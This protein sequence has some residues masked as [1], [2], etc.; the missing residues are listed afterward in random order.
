[1]ITRIKFTACLVISLLS[2]TMAGIAP[3]IAAPAPGDINVF[4]PGT[5]KGDTIIPD[6]WLR[7]WD[8]ITIFFSDAMGPVE[9]SPENEPDK[10]ASIEPFHPGSWRW[11][12]AKTLQFKPAEPWPAFSSFSIRA[13]KAKTDL[14]TV[15]TGP[16]NTQPTQ[17][18]TDLPPVETISLTF[19][20]TIPASSLAAALSVTLWSTHSADG[21]PCDVYTADDF[22]VKQVGENAS[23]SDITYLVTLH[24]PVPHNT[25]ARLR[26]DLTR[27]ATDTA[28][29]FLD[30]STARSFCALAAGAGENWLPLSLQS[31]DR[32]IADPL[33]LDI[34]PPV[35]TIRMSAPLELLTPTA[36]WDFVHLT[37]A[38]GKMEFA[39]ED[40]LLKINGDFQPDTVYRATIRPTSLIRDSR[41]RSL[42]LDSPIEFPFVFRCPDRVLEWDRN[43]VVVERY[44]PKM[45]PLKG[46]G[47]HVADVRLYRVDP[48]DRT[49]WPFPAE[50]ITTNPETKPPFPSGNEQYHDQTYYGSSWELEETLTTMGS[51]VLSDIVE[52]PLN[53]MGDVRT[54][55]LD[56]EKYL[57][58]LEGES[59]P[60]TYLA[61]VQPLNDPG[62]RHW[63][64][65]QITDLALTTFEE[66]D[67][68]TFMVTSLK[69]AAPVANARVTLEGYSNREW[70]RILS[71][72]TDSMGVFTQ[73]MPSG[74]DY[75]NLKRIRVERGNDVLVVDTEHPP[76]LF[77]YGRWSREGDW[78]YQ[79]VNYPS[80]S[81]RQSLVGHLFT[82]RPVYRPGDP[83]H[84]RGWIRNRDA[85]VFALTGDTSFQISVE[86]PGGLFWTAQVTA[87]PK[88]GIYNRFHQLD[89]PV[90]SYHAS[91]M[92]NGISIATCNFRMED[93][94]LP[95]FE[96]LL[97]A[98][99]TV[100]LD[101]AFDITLTAKYY[102]GGAMIDRPVSWRVTQHP[103]SWSA[104][105][106]PGFRFAVD[107]R[108]TSRPGLRENDILN[109]VSK[110]DADGSARISIDPLTELS[111]SPRNYVIEA[112]V[113]GVDGQTVTAVKQIEALP[114][115]MLGM[116]TPRILDPG[117]P[118]KPQI[119]VLDT[120]GEFEPGREII[121]R[122]IR[123]TWHTVLKAGNYSAGDLK[124]DT[125]IVETPIM[126]T[127]VVSTAE[128]LELSFPIGEAG[129]YIVEASARDRIG[130]AQT[131]AMDVFVQGQT[132]VAW[133]RAPD[134]TFL[135]K[136]GKAAYEPGDT[137][138]FLV[139][140]PFQ[141]A[142]AV[143]VIE[144]PDGLQFHHASVRNGVCVIDVPVRDEW[145][146]EIPVNVVLMRGRLP[147]SRIE[148][149]TGIDLGKPQT[150]ATSV[151]LNV[152]K[153]RHI[154]AI[155]IEH[156]AR[157]V[158]GETIDLTVSLKNSN[159]E[160]VAGEAAVWLVDRAV[161]ALGHE[162]S[163]DPLRDLLIPFRSQLGIRD[164]REFVA[165]LL[166]GIFTTG[167]GYGED[168]AGDIFDRM[169]L[170]RKFEPVPFYEPF[171]EIGS[172]G[173]AHLKVT[174]PDNL[175]EFAVRAKACSGIDR[176]GATESRLAV[177]L[178]VVMQPTLPRFLRPGDQFEALG[179]SR[180]VEGEAGAGRIAIQTDGLILTGDPVEQVEWEF[181]V[182][183]RTNFNLKVPS[184]SAENGD[185]PVPGNALIRMAAERLK[186]GV[187][188]AAE[189]TLPVI[190][191]TPD[192]T[193]TW[194]RTL[195]PGETVEV[196]GIDPLVILSETAQ[197]GIR[198]STSPALLTAIRAESLL[199][200]Y[201]YGCTE[202]RLSRA[203]GL[204]IMKSLH[205]LLNRS[206]DESSYDA[207]I[208][209]TIDYLPIVTTPEGLVAFWP[210]GKGYVHLT[211]RALRFLADARNSGF[212]VD[213][214][215][216][217]Q[218]IRSLKASL[219]SD[220]R[221]LV[222][223]ADVEERVLALEALT[224]FGIEE[225]GYIEEMARQADGLG[226]ETRA[227]IVRLFAGLENVD[228]ARLNGLA[229]SLWNDVVF[230]TL[231]GRLTATGFRLGFR[232]IYPIFMSNTTAL[233]EVI[234]AMIRIAP[235]DQRIQAMT[236]GLV[237]TMDAGWV[238]TYDSA[239]TLDVLKELLDSGRI[240]HPESIVEIGGQR[241]SV[242][243]TRPLVILNDF[244]TGAISVTKVDGAP[245]TIHAD[246]R[247]RPVT[248]PGETPGES[249]GFAVQRDWRRV[250]VENRLGDIM[251]PD[252][253]GMD[254]ELTN[255][256]IVE[257]HIQ[258]VNPEDRLYIVVSAPLAAGM[259]PLN[260]EL[261]IAPP[262]ARP[263]GT[264]TLDADYME[265]R[266]HYIAW[267]YN[268]LPKG[269]YD[270]YFRTRASFAGRFTQPGARA[271]MMYDLDKTG[272][273]PGIHVRIAPDK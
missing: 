9:I 210:G 65:I 123:R 29:F 41:G 137:A 135:L 103:A 164:T 184:T 45:L 25:K 156:P 51:P 273:S 34:N 265:I 61:G 175:T 24:H 88:G 21:K 161:L 39:I 257:E 134:R 194:Q 203:T 126:T 101:A 141:T 96:V 206:I 91:V 48:L 99:D 20:E 238:S 26:L 259:E 199:R 130:R 81:H 56:L 232:A 97:H 243:A 214:S 165:G 142:E 111:L 6:R 17:G 166:P 246:Y 114:A 162:P 173:I 255:G 239:A 1:M 95:Q 11:L 155:G 187:G 60:G 62:P 200:D 181:N 147:G 223:G 125:H 226:T 55:G 54:Y 49:L 205:N 68:L 222:N 132:P 167:G 177:R 179:I 219:R 32:I 253:A 83:V 23:S 72:K 104:A 66:P 117:Q 92:Q 211:S 28:Q 8:P 140:S 53:P 133:D 90:G 236:D 254:A 131:V 87:S 149:E 192:W 2:V 217:D 189:T 171:V 38:V 209:D 122:L 7:T 272:S 268:A 229:E 124:Y 70:T 144:S 245:V 182:P 13:G 74:S 143:A 178:P 37:P 40:R 86:G 197:R 227:R 269:T 75:T 128:P 69:T 172:N 10:F 115:F 50:T 67:R 107:D 47:Y 158:P 58:K 14:N 150:L 85:G 188:D 77:R 64:R 57:E 204:T 258:V 127:T 153:N 76:E 218:Y 89:A 266:D 228:N 129:V 168:K 100:P 201:P 82:E 59:T 108:F 224:L 79:V 35:L 154:A 106:L 230:E 52:L 261:A 84:I 113:T 216:A 252:H 102:A 30:F 120:T 146:P 235:D 121:V 202:Q 220:S 36:L 139:E 174:L 240:H 105:N 244:G 170:R 94:R 5:G 16:S 145:C 109:T 186:D 263:E 190:D 160:P 260:P 191:G 151:Q 118:V 119:A 208:R 31:A 169:S 215:L 12:N 262:E 196:P 112:T 152:S 163:P 198:I 185:R 212:D 22:S 80:D 267:Y 138:E 234:R 43:D 249:R 18:E 71:G 3:T 213:P 33:E 231:D 256:T 221:Y 157:A 248:A 42:D 15:I 264:Q 195:N 233:A 193:M 116:K 176:F 180:I 136:T 44:G 93:Y 250:T 207:M 241:V 242:G 247:G 237:N 225:T 4:R 110:T 251:V 98:G 27:P 78:L 271:C 73:I 270:F 63:M 19:R 159:S 148:G 46:R 183:L